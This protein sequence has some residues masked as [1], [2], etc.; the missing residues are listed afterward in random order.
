M[1]TS[2]KPYEM[3]FYLLILSLSL[4]VSCQDNPPLTQNNGQPGNSTNPYSARFYTN[5][6][7]DWDNWKFETATDDGYI[8]TAFSEDW[9]NWDFDI[10]GY[11]G[12]IKTNFSEDWDNWRLYHSGSTITI[13]T[14][15]SEDW[16]SWKIYDPNTGDTFYVRTSFSN[17]FDRWAVSLNGNTELNIRTRFSDDFDNWTVE[18]DI[19]LF[20]NAQ[21]VA[22]FFVPLF[23]GALH[24]QGIHEW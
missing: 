14:N 5:F 6:S 9:D 1:V 24:N 13:Q 20:S 16:D 10:S 18:G 8:R 3:K 7:E 2:N 11:T 4:L 15:F 12:D 22:I 19:E 21:K 17:D 23:A